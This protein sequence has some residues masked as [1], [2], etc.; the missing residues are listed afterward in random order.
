M[1]DYRVWCLSWDDDE[2]FGKTYADKP[3]ADALSDWALDASN[4]A[5]MYA[6]DCHGNRDCWDSSWPL[7]F[8]VRLPDGTTEDFEVDREMVPEFHARRLTA[9]EGK[10]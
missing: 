9:A 8:R 6:G 5:E 4:A 10:P 2:D 7:K 3:T 1:N